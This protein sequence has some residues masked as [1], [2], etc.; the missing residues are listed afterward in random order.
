[1]A[2]KFFSI[3]KLLDKLT[4]Y[5]RLKGEQFKLEIMGK[6]AKTASYLIVAF[7]LSLLIFFLAFFIGFA[8]AAYLNELIGVAYAGYLIVGGIILLKIIVVLI[9]LKTGYLQKKLEVLILTI[10]EDDE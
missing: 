9:M 8:I 7:F 6:V 2:G 1:M 5:A 10:T 3:N 4:D